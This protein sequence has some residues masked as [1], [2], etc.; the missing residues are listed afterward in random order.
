[1]YVIQYNTMKRNVMKF[2][3][4]AHSQIM[5]FVDRNWLY[6]TLGVDTKSQT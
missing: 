4:V 2:M 3:Y 1:M 6:L 5:D